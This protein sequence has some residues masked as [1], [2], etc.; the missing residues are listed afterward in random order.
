[1]LYA[2]CG[3][4]VMYLSR[5]VQ[6]KNRA[7][8]TGGREAPFLIIPL[9]LYPLPLTPLLVDLENEEVSKVKIEQDTQVVGRRRPGRRKTQ[10]CGNLR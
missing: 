5:S 2:D 3:Y 1:M 6:S 9:P 8:R 7:R 10:W 4:Q